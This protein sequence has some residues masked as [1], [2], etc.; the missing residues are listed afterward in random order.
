L[1]AEPLR[2]P[3]AEEREGSGQEERGKICSFQ[4]FEEIIRVHPVFAA[5]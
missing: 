5:A 2:K 1:T 4:D 3:A